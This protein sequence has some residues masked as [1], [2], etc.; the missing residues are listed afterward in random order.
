VVAGIGPCDVVNAQGT[1][2]L[3]RRTAGR[4]GHGNDEDRGGDNAGNMHRSTM[5][6]RQ[7]ARSRMRSIGAVEPLRVVPQQRH[8]RRLRPMWTPRLRAAGRHQVRQRDRAGPVRASGGRRDRLVLLVLGERV[9]Q[10]RPSTMSRRI[11]SAS[12][13]ARSRRRSRSGPRSR[14]STSCITATSSMPRT[15]PARSS[16]PVIC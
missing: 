16:S 1:V 2:F 14:L 8:Q 5:A 11:S 7:S 3:L 10:L 13:R 12:R 4:G 15:R 6:G 9:E